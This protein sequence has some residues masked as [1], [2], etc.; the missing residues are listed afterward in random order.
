MKLTRRSALVSTLLSFM[1]TRSAAAQGESVSPWINIITWTPIAQTPAERE[2]E[3]V[4]TSFQGH[5]L[6]LMY[7]FPMDEL[8]IIAMHERDLETWLLLLSSKTEI[9]LEAGSHPD[10]NAALAPQGTD[11]WALAFAKNINSVFLQ[12]DGSVPE[13][14]LAVWVQWVAAAAQ[15]LTSG[16]FRDQE[17]TILGF[18]QL[19]SASVDDWHSLRHWYGLPGVLNVRTFS[20]L[21]DQ[22]TGEPPHPSVSFEAE[23]QALLTG[24]IAWR[25][26]ARFPSFWM[27][28]LVTGFHTISDAVRDIDE[29]AAGFWD[30]VETRIRLE[31]WGWIQQAEREFAS[32]HNGD[33]SVD[34]DISIHTFETT[35][36]AQ[37]AGTWF[38]QR[39]MAAL[40]LKAT[41]TDSNGL[42]FT[43]PGVRERLRGT[44]N[45]DE[46]SLF[47]VHGNM[48]ARVTAFG[49]QRG[50]GYPNLAAITM[51]RILN[52]EVDYATMT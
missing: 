24:A 51:L 43:Q 22:A 35:A 15:P 17:Q 19:M 9:S 40:G 28:D 44:V 23:G 10:G 20:H 18:W 8:P 52:R 42:R 1:G 39:R 27:P 4:E 7:V 32:D 13:E 31:A 47:L 38:R 46:Y 26:D 3:L 11:D 30:P 2:S 14:L 36:G 5:A 29:V 21:A 49:D 12:V 34:L 16:I 33:N 50:L 45:A 41:V 48:F 37:L 6:R 25:N